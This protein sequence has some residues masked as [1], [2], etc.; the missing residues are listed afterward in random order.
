MKKTIFKLFLIIIIFSLPAYYF[1]QR[2]QHTQ[3]LLSN[4]EKLAEV[5]TN[6]L[7]KNVS[8]IID[9]PE[10][11]RPEVRT[12]V[13]INKVQINPFFEKAKNGDKLLLYLVA[14]KAF[15]YRPSINKIINVGPLTANPINATSSG[16]IPSTLITSPSASASPTKSTGNQ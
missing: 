16:S 13:D 3:S 4:P 11:E 12:V 15:L 1:Y 5:Q 8:L 10:N 7:L 9:L 2:Y 14:K 6:E